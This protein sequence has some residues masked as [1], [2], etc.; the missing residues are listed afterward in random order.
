MT[1]EGPK[2]PAVRSIAW[3]DRFGGHNGTAQW[4]INKRALRQTHGQTGT[5]ELLVPAREQILEELS[6][7]CPA[8]ALVSE[9]RPG[10]QLSV[11][12]AHGSR[13]EQAQRDHLDGVLQ[14]AVIIHE[15]HLPVILEL[16]S[17]L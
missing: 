4:N 15:R 6:T 14:G 3:L 16:A 12:L 1:A 9:N 10:E 8:A 13:I 17:D 2:L 5:H 11:V 7:R